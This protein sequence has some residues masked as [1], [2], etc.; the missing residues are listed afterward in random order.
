MSGRD[1]AT[2][3]AALRELWHR[4]SAVVERFAR[5]RGRRRLRASEYRPLHQGLLRVCRS[6]AAQ[7]EGPARGVYEELESIAQP[8]LTPWVLEQAD[9]EILFDLVERC[10][11]AGRQLG[12]PPWGYLA[13][14]C[15]RPGL[16]LA[17]AA[18]GLVLLAW[19]GDRVGGPLLEHVKDAA[20]ALRWAARQARDPSWWLGGAL[21]T[22]LSIWVVIRAARS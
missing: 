10:R 18:A 17:A 5:R 12:G 13:R 16:A 19:A 3:R 20:R 15:V 8:W 9:R 21:A 14:A 22:L 11:R 2:E 4:W 7:T 1:S 6:L